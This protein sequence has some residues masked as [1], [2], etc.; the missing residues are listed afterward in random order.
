MRVASEDWRC[1][2]HPLEGGVL[3][4]E[5]VVARGVMRRFG[6]ELALDEEAEDSEAVV[7]GD[8]DDVTLSEEL[9]VLSR[10]GR[11]ARD[12]AAAVDPDHHGKAGLLRLRGSPHVQC[13]AV[14]TGAGIAEYHVIVYGRLH[15]ARAELG[16][17]ADALPFSRGLRWL[18]AELADGRSGV[19]DSFKGSDLSIEGGRALDFAF[20]G[21]DLE[22][23]GGVCGEREEHKNE[24][25]KTHDASHLDQYTTVQ[26]GSSVRR[27]HSTFHPLRAK[28]F[29]AGLDNKGLSLKG[30]FI[31]VKTMV[32][33][34]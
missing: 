31:I 9:A 7:H 15:A 1:L 30:G 8:Y 28:F 18:P 23:I 13:E 3:I 24:E 14:F 11:A 10:L 22:G 29:I 16:R 25:R 2:L 17:V 20:S 5:A 32:L 33:R 19:G 12:I 34:V 27:R 21:F 26:V 4:H 6:G